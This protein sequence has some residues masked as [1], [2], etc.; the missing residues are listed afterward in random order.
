MPCFY[1]GANVVEGFAVDLD[2]LG[3]IWCA[4]EDSMEGDV[5]T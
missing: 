1:V 2:V 4:V 3:W 5:P